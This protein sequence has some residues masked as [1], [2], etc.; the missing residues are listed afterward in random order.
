MSV[1]TYIDA[2]YSSQCFLF[3]SVNSNEINTLHSDDE[4]LRSWSHL[5]HTLQT[6][7]ISDNDIA[8]IDENV[9]DFYERLTWLNVDSNKLWTLNARSLPY[10]LR[11]LSY[12][13]NYVHEFPIDILERLPNLS[14]LYVRGNYIRQLPLHAFKTLKRMDKLDLGENHIEFGSSSNSTKHVLTV[15]DLHLDFNR[16]RFIPAHAFKGVSVARL[17]LSR[18]NMDSID[19]NAFRDVINSLEYLDLEHN[20]LLQIPSALAPLQRLKYLYISSN[21]IT[22]L[23]TDSLGEFCSSLKAISL[24]GNQLTRIPKTALQ[25]CDKLSHLNIGYN[26]VRE[27]SEQDFESWG[28][29]L[30]TLLLRNNR[31]SEIG[32]HAF[33][34]TPKLQELSLSFNKLVHIHE[35]AFNESK[36]SLES[37]EISFGLFQEEFT[38]EFLKPLTYLLWLALDNNN[39]NALSASAFHPLQNLQ[40]LNLDTNA[41]T[42]VPT[43]LLT[44][45]AHK[46]LKD[47]RLSNNHLTLLRTRMFVDLPELQNIILSRNQMRKIEARSFLNLINAANIVISGNRIEKIDAH[48]FVNLPNLMKLDLQRNKLSTLNMNAFVNVSSPSVPFSLNVSENEL[49]E[50]E[51]NPNSVT[52]LHL[53]HLDASANQMQNIPHSL[54]A[55]CSRSITRLDF[56]L[57][58]VSKL[59][60]NAFR[61]LSR[62]ESLSLAT[63]Q[64]YFVHKRA[65]MHLDS[66]QV[67][68]LSENRIE[69]LYSETFRT[70][71]NLRILNLAKN[72]LR[73][74]SNDLFARTSLEAI[75]LS[76]NLLD[77]MPSNAISEVGETLRKL[78]LSNNH[79]E[80][81]DSTMFAAVTGLSSLNLVG[82]KLSILPDNVFTSVGNLLTLDLS[83]NPLRA[84]FKEL[85][86]Y[87]QKLRYLN[88]AETGLTEVPPLPLPNL[89]E[90]RLSRNRIEKLSSVSVD[91]LGQ[92]RRLYLDHNRFR[93]LPSNAWPYLVSLKELD[94]SNN[95]IKVSDDSL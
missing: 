4:Y 17:Y 54:L 72:N 82:N 75:D 37:L 84:N 77:V 24:S 21:R 90:L 19:E 28:A 34:Q 40:Y 9:L 36:M 8:Q 48:A 10:A 58:R 86:H 13:Q 16:I 92:L 94:V 51:V 78:D 33:R 50:I 15:R 66:L 59:N 12:C 55:F 22:N 25:R 35:H 3:S 44:S 88:L 26:Y 57:N 93:T 20:N 63:N 68:D 67:L 79:I 52:P 56:K 39:I 23:T 70:M 64:I 46:H 27:I 43:G 5:K 7:F 71:K 41:I 60:E 73:S 65:F 31:L 47:V 62:L 14:R 81:L 1:F 85:F 6:L 89:I 32:A 30:N 95:P 83:V 69:D 29:S 38:G 80:H 76:G 74:L 87:V 53:S 42:E 18:N 49:H 91:N 45:K 11:T 2:Q 61:N